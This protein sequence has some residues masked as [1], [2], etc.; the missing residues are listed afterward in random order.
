MLQAAL[1]PTN[2]VCHTSYFDAFLSSNL[3]AMST[4]S[5]HENPLLFRRKF[6]SILQ[7][8][9]KLSPA[10][11]REQLSLMR[12]YACGHLTGHRRD[13]SCSTTAALLWLNEGDLTVRSEIPDHFVK[14]VAEA[15]M[16]KE[17]V[18]VSQIDCFSLC[19]KTFLYVWPRDWDKPSLNLWN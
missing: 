17:Q 13:K 2:T 5:V 4:Q 10:P 14:S 19:A 3:P 12:Q 9:F 6:V 8:E 1:V 18:G 11:L 7:S 16:L 15:A